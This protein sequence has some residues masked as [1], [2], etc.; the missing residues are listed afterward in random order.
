MIEREQM[1]MHHLRPDWMRVILI[2][3]WLEQY[4]LVEKRFGVKTNE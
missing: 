4:F 2:K 1:R 3:I